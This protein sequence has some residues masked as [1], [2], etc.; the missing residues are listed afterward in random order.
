ML[1]P[2]PDFR[3]SAYRHGARQVSLSGAEIATHRAV[4]ADQLGVDRRR[5]GHRVGARWRAGENLPMGVL[6]VVPIQIHKALPSIAFSRC[7]RPRRM[8][9]RTSWLVHFGTV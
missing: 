9:L 5:R 6:S 4:E 2:G 1:L 7:V 3:A 8:A